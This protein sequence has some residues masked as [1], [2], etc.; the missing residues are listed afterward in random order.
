MP[1]LEI[2][3]VIDAGVIAEILEGGWESLVSASISAP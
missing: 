1:V 3:V 2:P